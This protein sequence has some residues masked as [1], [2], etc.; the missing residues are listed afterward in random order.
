M[1]FLK[2]FLN[3]VLV[4]HEFVAAISLTLSSESQGIKYLC[5][6]SD[7]FYEQFHIM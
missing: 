6:L 4:Q 7:R 1:Y 2:L 3:I 5:S